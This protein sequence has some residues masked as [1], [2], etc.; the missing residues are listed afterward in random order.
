LAGRTIRVDFAKE[1]PEK[2]KEREELQAAE[3]AAEAEGSIDNLH[4][5]AEDL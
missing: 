3:A 2:L 1:D 4:D 5:G